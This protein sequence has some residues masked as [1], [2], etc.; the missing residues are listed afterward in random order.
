MRYLSDFCHF[1]RCLYTMF[2]THMWKSQGSLSSFPHQGA[3]YAQTERHILS[4]VS[5]LL[6]LAAPSLLLQ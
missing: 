2:L 5:G 1:D 3:Q 6:L 4:A